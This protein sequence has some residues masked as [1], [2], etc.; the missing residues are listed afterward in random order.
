[1]NYLS[2][3]QRPTV[4]QS[5]QEWQVADRTEGGAAQ[6]QQDALASRDG[7]Q[8]RWERASGAQQAIEHRLPAVLVPTAQRRWTLFQSSQPMVDRTWFG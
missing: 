5:R 6:S 8:N 7:W 1:V 4:G 2:H 3:T